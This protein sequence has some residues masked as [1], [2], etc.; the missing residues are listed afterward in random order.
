MTQILEGILAD[1]AA[2]DI[3][4]AL[5][6]ASVPAGPIHSVGDAL[7]NPQVLAREMVISPEGVRGIRGP[8]KFSD[9]ELSL[10][11]SAPVFPKG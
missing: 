8:W 5:E 4:A 3:I 1:W 9:A 10:V 2:A 11:R 6:A 7:Q